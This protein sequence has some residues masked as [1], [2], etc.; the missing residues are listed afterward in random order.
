MELKKLQS[1][2]QLQIGDKVTRVTIN[3]F[4]GFVYMGDDPH[5][6]NPEYKN[7]YGYFL[8]SFGREKVERL[9]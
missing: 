1:F 6:K 8:D 9:S 4:Q 3:G 5:T 2:D 7:K